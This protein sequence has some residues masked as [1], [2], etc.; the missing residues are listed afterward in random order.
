MRFLCETRPLGLA[1]S[2]LPF[3][4]LASS[5]VRHAPAF[6]LVSVRGFLFSFVIHLDL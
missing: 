3:C 6:S 5:P 4:S 1:E 2:S